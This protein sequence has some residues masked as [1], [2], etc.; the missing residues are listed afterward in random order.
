MNI[1]KLAVLLVSCAALVMA[2]FALTS[3]GPNNEELIEQAVTTKYDAYKNADDASLSNIATLLEN[4]GVAQLGIDDQEFVSALI[5]GFDYSIDEI[6]VNGDQALVT[7]TFAGK[8]YT[9][10]LEQIT[11]MTEALANDP[12]FMAMPQDEKYTVVGQRVMEA[13]NNLEVKN[14]TVD[15][16]Y[17]LVDNKWQESD[18]QEG[19]AQI[20]NILFA[21]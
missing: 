17:E 21:K 15:L 7:M 10:L 12:E 2:T 1:K 6:Q 8:S 20:D 16:N 14:E 19:L 13:F 9:D 5:D 11:D 18:E 3:C 4:Q